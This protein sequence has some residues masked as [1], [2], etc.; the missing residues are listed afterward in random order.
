M[1][2]S[3]MLHS[4]ECL[5]LADILDRIVAIVQAKSNNQKLAAALKYK[6]VKNKLLHERDAFIVKRI[7]ET[8]KD[9]ERGI[10]FI[11]NL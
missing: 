9:G 5:N 8:L 6:L 11:G 1:Y 10:I 2:E 4:V 7:E 3:N